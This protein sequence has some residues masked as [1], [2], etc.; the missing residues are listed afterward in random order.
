[1]DYKVLYRKYRPINFEQLIGQDSIKEL[2]IN[3]ILN[4]KISHAYIFTGPRGTGKTSTAKIFARTINCESLNGTIPCGECVACVSATDS[5]DIIEIDAASNNGVE[6]IRE[7]R[8]NVKIS[9]SY[10]KYKI[11]IIDEVHMLSTNA[12]NAFLKTLEEPPGHVIFILATTE[13]QKVPI[14]VLSRCQRFDFKKITQPVIMNALKNIAESENIS[15]TEEALNEISKLADGAMRDALGILDQL[16]KSA[17]QI[18]LETM[19]KAYG[20]ITTDDI[21]TI[22][23]FCLEGNHKGIISQ[24]DDF[25]DM[26]IDSE[27]LLNHL[28]EYAVECLIT[29]RTETV[30]SDFDIDSFVHSLESCYGKANQYILIKICLLKHCLQENTKKN[31]EHNVTVTEVEDKPEGNQEIISREIIST[32]TEE[33]NKII[34]PDIIHIRVNNAFVGAELSLKKDYSIVWTQFIEHLIKS[35]DYKYSS[36][37]RN[38]EIQVVSP[39]NVLI[40]TDSYSNSVLVNSL[41]SEIAERIKQEY[42]IDKKIICLDLEAWK[43]EKTEYIKNKNQKKYE[44]LKEPDLESKHHFVDSA[45]NL[46]GNELVEIR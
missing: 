35:E 18:T 14:T 23:K 29:R 7:I 4:S 31:V 45:E 12:W 16:S 36:L 44:L 33:E 32:I 15:I 24:I 43:L 6:E 40:S 27:I 20:I 39:T 25:K 9:P 1:M 10:S 46:F 37:L 8:D 11:Y 28:L 5:A 2:L 13:I 22:F 26:G 41:A 3:S 30:Y 21:E 19:K 42:S 38:T 34:E 17:N